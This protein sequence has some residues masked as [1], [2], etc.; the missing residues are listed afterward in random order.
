MKSSVLVPSR[1]K[2][3][4]MTGDPVVLRIIFSPGDN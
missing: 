1:Y 4:N 3:S 2:R